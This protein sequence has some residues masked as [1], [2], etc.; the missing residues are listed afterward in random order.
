M[1]PQIVFFIGKPGSGK[2]TQADLLAQATGWPVITAG[3]QFRKIATEDSLVGR[4]VKVTIDAGILTPP[5]FP[6]YLYLKSLFSISE[7]S[8]AIFDGF[9]RKVQEAELIID[10]LNWLE[11]P[12][13]VLDIKISDEEVLHRI[14]LRKEVE[15]RVDDN[16]IQTR[17]TEYNK[18][19]DPAIELF[20]K[21]GVLVEV[22]GERTPEVIAAEA[23]QILKV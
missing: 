6:M 4:K 1:T 22:N 15:G 7:H 23:R 18:F 11:R 5:W 13:T 16:V 21:A 9:N 14:S 10:S 20:R 12:F 3:E 8:G 17:L 2:G 19:T